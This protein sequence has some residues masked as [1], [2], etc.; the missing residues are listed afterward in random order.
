MRVRRIVLGGVALAVATFGAPATA[1]AAPGDGNPAQLCKQDVGGIRDFLTTQ[2]G[3]TSSI[4]SV[5]VDALMTGAFP[6]TAAAVAN[7]KDLEETFFLEG[8]PDGARPYPYAF[9]GNAHLPAYV[10][11]NRADCVQILEALHTGQLPPGPQA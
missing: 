10:A 9:Y 3:C 5:G 11:E 1:G 2:G 6:S 8:K 4:A 7:C